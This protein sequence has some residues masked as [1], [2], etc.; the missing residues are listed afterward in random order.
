[1]VFSSV[2]FLFAF[3]PLTLAVY[4]ALP[5][6]VR[7]GVLLAASLLFYVSG[8]PVYLWVMLASI[9]FNYG[10]GLAVAAARGRLKRGV[11]AGAVL[12][13]IG[14]L[15]FFKYAA[16]FTTTL[17]STLSTALTVP[18]VALPVGISFFTFH[19]L[20]YVFDIY[21]GN[22]PAQRNPFALAL[23]ILLFPQLIAGPIVRYHAIAPQLRKREITAESFTEG[24]YRFVIGLSKKVLIANV[25]ARVADTVFAL[26]PA[27]IGTALAWLGIAC[28]TLQIYFDFSGYSDMAV[29][30]GLMFG[31]RL[32]E[33]FNYPYAARSIQDFWRRWHITLSTWFRDYVYIP[34]GGNR[35]GAVR[36]YL[37]LYIVFFLTGLWHGASWTF[38]LWG[39]LH[40]TFLV[41]ERLGFARVL[42]WLPRL[43]QHGY[44]LLVVMCAWVLFRSDTLPYAV[45]YLA[46]MFSLSPE[47]TIYHLSLYLDM[48]TILALLMGVL[49]SFHSAAL[50]KMRVVQPEAAAVVRLAAC[51]GLF[52]L[53]AM[54]LVV[55]TYNPFIYFRF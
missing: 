34:L 25:V 31:F 20:S 52:I 42:E 47:G 55:N 44:A 43:A 45:G 11:L 46:R 37:N 19:A 28:Y 49:F 7:N 23:Y 26:D 48:R 4:F 9:T 10:F 8:E 33:N 24:I 6:R 21:R 13:N 29:G 51:A 12:V 50:L 35:K 40:G 16:F 38:V 22:A 1:V 36:T 2:I 41:V 15:G 32:P 27:Q 3:L 54:T 14:L 5:G 53:C 30:L 17:N 39:L 18:A